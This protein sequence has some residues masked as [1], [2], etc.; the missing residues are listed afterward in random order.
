[1]IVERFHI[2]G[3]EVIVRYPKN[4]NVYEA[5][6]YI[7]SLVEE[8]APIARTKKA[9]LKEE[10]EF[11]K[12]TLK[13]IKSNQAVYLAAEINGKIVSMC[14]VERGEHGTSEHVGTFAIAV[15]KDYRGLG[16]GKR[17]M[18]K[19]INF[20]KKKM[21]IKIVKLEVFSCNT[22]AIKLYRLLGFKKAGLIPDGVKY[23]GKY[24]D[25]IIMVKI[26]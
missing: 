9:T 21:K 19:V 11:I 20:A 14:S 4:S 15:I 22:G 26:L 1:M 16:I 13:K 3:K 10:K 17:M 24:C 25:K 7:N 12:S 6:R 18:Q 23:K 5:R 8:K 2:Q